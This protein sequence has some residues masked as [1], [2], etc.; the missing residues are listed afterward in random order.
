L[1]LWVVRLACAG[2]CDDKK[3]DTTHGSKRKTRFPQD[4]TLLTLC[5]SD[6]DYDGDV[7]SFGVRVSG[8]DEHFPEYSSDPVYHSDEYAA[9]SI[10]APPPWIPTYLINGITIDPTVTQP[11]VLWTHIPSSLPIDGSLG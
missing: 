1:F 10:A 9:E 11:C 4:G 3:R 8:S 7:G 2:Y 6:L 5:S